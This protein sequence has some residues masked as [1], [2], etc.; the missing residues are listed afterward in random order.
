MPTVTALAMG[1][2]PEGYGTGI[3]WMVVASVVAP[4]ALLLLIAWYGSRNDV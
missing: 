3:E 4:V 1:P 2:M